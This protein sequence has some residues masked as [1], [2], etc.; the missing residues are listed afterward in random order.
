MGGFGGPSNSCPSKGGGAPYVSSRSRDTGG[1]TYSPTE[2][3][4]FAIRSRKGPRFSP[5]EPRATKHTSSSRAPKA[6]NRAASAAGIKNTRRP[7]V[8]G[9]Q[10][11]GSWENSRSWK[12]G[13]DGLKTGSG[14]GGR[15]GV[16]NHRPSRRSRRHLLPRH[17]LVLFQP[18]SHSKS[19]T[20]WIH[21]DRNS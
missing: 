3:S 8:P 5:S 7:S 6:T 21:L 13:L 17:L 11:G 20:L 2:T 10:R 1:W 14:P 19:S 18:P 4:S 12:G 9:G 16:G 15:W